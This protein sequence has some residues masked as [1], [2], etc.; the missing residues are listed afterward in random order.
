MATPARGVMPFP[1]WLRW[2]F[3]LHDCLTTGNTFLSMRSLSTQQ[4]RAGHQLGPA[5]SGRPIPKDVLRDAVDY[6]SFAGGKEGCNPSGVREQP[7][8]TRS[9]AFDDHVDVRAGQ[10]GCPLLPKVGDWP[11]GSIQASFSSYVV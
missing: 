7:K 1:P 5:N 4:G 11:L 10:A 8:T 6:Q 2:R 3:A 9:R